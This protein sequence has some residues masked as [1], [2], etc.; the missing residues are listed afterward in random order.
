MVA[1]LPTVTGDVGGNSEAITHM[2]TGL[3]YDPTQPDAVANA[4]KK[5]LEQP[6][7]SRQLA[8]NARTKALATYSIDQMIKNHE[9]YYESL[10]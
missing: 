8:Q 1:G 2:V 5:L 9:T 4:I 7:L 6:A 10:I 3:L